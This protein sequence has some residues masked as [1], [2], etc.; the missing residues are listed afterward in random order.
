VG[1]TKL[2]VLALQAV[3]MDGGKTIAKT[4]ALV[5]QAGITQHATEK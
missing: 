5:S 4:I 1:K 3:P 2:Q